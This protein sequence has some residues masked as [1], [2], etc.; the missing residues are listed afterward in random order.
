M[1]RIWYLRMDFDFLSSPS[2]LFSLSLTLSFPLSNSSF[3]SHTRFECK[4][5]RIIV[6]D[7]VCIYI[8]GECDCI[9]RLYDDFPYDFP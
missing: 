1:P 3:A 7:S 5:D 9:L 8:L 2:P 6:S 4:F